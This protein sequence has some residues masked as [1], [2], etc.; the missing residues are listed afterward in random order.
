MWVQKNLEHFNDLNELLN[1]LEQFTGDMKHHFDDP[2]D[3][4]GIF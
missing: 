2:M 1:N 4:S 3:D